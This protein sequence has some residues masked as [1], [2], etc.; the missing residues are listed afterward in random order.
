MGHYCN[1]CDV[2]I[3]PSE[4]RDDAD[5]ELEP[6]V[7]VAAVVVVVVAARDDDAWRRRERG[8]AWRLVKK[9]RTDSL[10]CTSVQTTPHVNKV[11]LNCCLKELYYSVSVSRTVADTT[12]T[13]RAVSSWWQRWDRNIAKVKCQ[14][15]TRERQEAKQQVPGGGT[16]R[17]SLG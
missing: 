6:Q 4:G 12:S 13:A 17:C 2:D 9:G 5:C 14:K 8:I 1:I 15:Q 16:R 7:V 3:E 10:V 11:F